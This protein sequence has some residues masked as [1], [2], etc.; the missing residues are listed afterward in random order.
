[1]DK[2][3]PIR[4]RV[5]ELE[6]KRATRPDP[7]AADYIR[8]SC[9]TIKLM[10]HLR[11]CGCQAA[12]DALSFVMEHL[13]NGTDWSEKKRKFVERELTKLDKRVWKWQEKH[14]ELWRKELMVPP[15]PE[16]EPGRPSLHLVT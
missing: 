12:S 11:T 5:S 15:E 6:K 4:R 3:Y 10:D 14:P 9:D 7:N 8:E 1:M 16:P 13:V 2:D